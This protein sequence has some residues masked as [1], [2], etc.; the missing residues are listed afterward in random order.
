MKTLILDNF[1]SFTYN[2]YQYVAELGG[3]PE[4]FR[5]NEITLD[6]IKKLGFTHIIISPGPGS[7]D[8]IKDFGVCGKVIDEFTG[9]LPILGVCLGHQGIIHRLGG[10]VMRAP[11]PV[12]GKRSLIGV[13]NGNPLFKGLPEVIE[14]MRYHSLLGESKSL[15]DSLEIIAET[16]NDKLIMGVA[17]K[18]FPLFG[19]QFHPESIGTPNGKQ[20]LKNFLGLTTD[21]SEEQAEKL[22]RDMGTGKL[23]EKEMEDALKRLAEKGESVSEIVGAARAMRKMAVTLP[24]KNEDS[25]DTCGTGGSGLPRMNI[26]T[27]VAFVLAAAGIKIAK[28]GNRAASGRCGSFDLLE[29]L[30]VNINLSPEAI[31]ESIKKLGIGF[32]F[33]PAFH[34]AMKLIAP[35][36]KKLGT[37]TIFNLL[38]PLTNPAHPTHHLLGT[39]SVK[40]AKKMIEAM[41][42]LGYKRAIVVCGEDG[43]DEVTITGKTHVFDLKNGDVKEFDFSP[44]EV[45]INPAKSFDE[46]AGGTAEQNAETFLL[47]L[48]NK[49][50]KQLQNLLALNCAFGL[51]VGGVS[52][53]LVDG[54]TKARKIIAD[55]AAYKKFMEYKDFSLSHAK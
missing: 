19:V 47:L 14:G 40:I 53:N 46:I 51:V 43:L 32:I 26:S 20:I 42:N 3:N 25:M 10:K 34:P 55:G 33:A 24:I 2:L 15:P 38:G 16:V 9:K 45:G 6:E 54:L 8:N 31:A 12:H 28:H 27:A 49:E 30:G 5:N 48:Q 1:D 13:Q 39:T 21:L 18:E 44:K 17:H 37:R 29:Q 50:P 36:R 23:T 41:K 35:V 11:V 7:P 52:K 22:V 4:V